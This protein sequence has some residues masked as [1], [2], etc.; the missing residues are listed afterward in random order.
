MS[1]KKLT[2]VLF[3]EKIE[4]VLPFWTEHLG[5]I[6]SI[7]VPDGEQL[8]FVALQQ[9]TA[10]VMYQSYAS[11]DKDMPAI[12]MDVRRG[13]TFLY[14][15]VGNLG[16]IKA[17]TGGMEIYMPERTTFYGSREIGVKDPAGHFI[18]FAHFEK[19]A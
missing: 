10:E 11:V 14:L 18:T 2:P 8:A 16:T 12:A 3:V 9:G 13:R 6:K 1:V 5:F 19:P 15:E 17:A 4:A 7:E